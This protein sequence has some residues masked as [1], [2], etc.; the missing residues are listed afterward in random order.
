MNKV[1]VKLTDTQLKKLKTA[2]KNK[3]GTTLRMS[4]KILDGNDLPHELLLT[5]QKTKLRNAFNSN[6][7]TDVKLSKAQIS[8][9][10][11]SGG[12]LGSLLSKLA[13]PLMKVAVPLAKNILAPLGITAA[14]LAIDAGI[15]KKICGSGRL[16]STTLIHSDKEMNDI[17]KIVQAFEDSN[18]LLKGVTKTIKIETK[19][20]KGGFL[21]MLL[22]TLGANLLGNIVTGKGLVRAGSG[23]K[24]RKGIVRAGYGKE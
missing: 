19:E 13:G 3:T 5:R 18:I 6:M 12:F 7:S 24:K 9:I 22:G 8:K 2:V 17:M 21:S 4:L 10:I 14:A 11:Q 15:Q 1:N 23:N 20:Q 16:L